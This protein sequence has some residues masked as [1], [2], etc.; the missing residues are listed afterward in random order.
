MAI[1]NPQAL[2]CAL[3]HETDW[4]EFKVNQFD[5]DE[6]GRYTSALANSAMLG[7]Q[8]FGYLVFGVEDKTHRIVGTDVSLKTATK[9]NELFENWLTRWLDPWLNL[10]RRIC[11]QRRPADC[12]LAH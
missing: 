7:D 2:L 1:V 10:E 9:G 11:I 12:D 3:P 4:L 5:P 6:I 8:Q